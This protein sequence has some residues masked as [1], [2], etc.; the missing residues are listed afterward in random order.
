MIIE[1]LP[2]KL[3]NIPGT[4][5][6]GYDRGRVLVGDYLSDFELIMSFLTPSWLKPSLLT[7]PWLMELLLMLL[8]AVAGFIV[9]GFI[10]S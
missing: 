8:A 1:P 3:N 10:V 7:L 9:S 2:G 6:A 4:H 5:P